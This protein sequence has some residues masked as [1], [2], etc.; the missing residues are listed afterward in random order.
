M[1]SVVFNHHKRI[2]SVLFFN[3][4]SVKDPVIAAWEQNNI[5]FCALKR[6]NVLVM[7]EETDREDSS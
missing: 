2:N 3:L 7:Q 5:F 1:I 6:T 4:T